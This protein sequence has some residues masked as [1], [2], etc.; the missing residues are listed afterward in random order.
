MIIARKNQ[1]G[2]DFVRM[3]W[4][5]KRITRRQVRASAFD[6]LLNAAGLI[7]A[8]IFQ[9]QNRINP[10]LATERLVAILKSPSG[11]HA[12]VARRGLALKIELRSPLCGY[13]V[14]HFHIRRRVGPLARAR[15]SG[16]S[17]CLDLEIA[18]FFHVM[19]VS[20]KKRALLP[21]GCSR[22]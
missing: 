13:P 16:G 9:I 3:L 19:R 8:L 2:L 10:V 4:S 22:Q 20:H 1:L 14:F 17:R 12:A 18:R 15:N 21:E 5:E 7:Y 6:L 11:K